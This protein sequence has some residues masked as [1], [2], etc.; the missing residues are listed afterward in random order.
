MPHVEALVALG[1]PDRRGQAL[2]SWAGQSLRP[3][4]SDAAAVLLDTLAARMTSLDACGFPD[5]LVH[6]DLWPGNAVGDDEHLVLLDWGDC[7]LGH[8]GFDIL[9]L[10]ERLEPAAT[11][12]LLDAWAGAWAQAVPGCEPRRAL[13]LLRPLAPLRMAAVYADFLAGI[14]PT[15]R[16]YHAADVP[17]C[18]DLAVAAA[19][20]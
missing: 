18:L 2:A 15:E 11:E 13:D 6:G 19:R 16:P 20:G 9:R 7:F 10:V 14:E 5:V 1:V 8:P 4:A 17:A 12:E 3:Y